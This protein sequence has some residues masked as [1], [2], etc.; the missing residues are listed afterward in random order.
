MTIYYYC[1]V[2]FGSLLISTN[3]VWSDYFYFELVT[4]WTV[5]SLETPVTVFP[6]LGLF[7]NISTPLIYTLMDLYVN[8]LRHSK[9]TVQIH[10]SFKRT[11]TFAT[12]HTVPLEENRMCK[13]DAFSLSSWYRFTIVS[14]VSKEQD[15]RDGIYIY[16][17]DLSLCS[18]PAFIW[19]CGARSERH[20]R[21][22]CRRSKGAFDWS[23]SGFGMLIQEELSCEE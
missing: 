3:C 23:S 21:S 6:R 18:D 15:L 8:S 9:A 10:L 22:Y 4:A 2:Y 12:F 14:F 19:P 16:K 7:P 1:E 11:M 17:R 13:S 20:K 5:Y